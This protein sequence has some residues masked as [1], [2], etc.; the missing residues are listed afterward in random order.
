M[1]CKMSD[2]NNIDYVYGIYVILVI[3]K[4]V[5]YYLIP[6]SGSM[7][8]GSAKVFNTGTYPSYVSFRGSHCFK[9]ERKA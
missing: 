9:H 4:R 8:F 7:S 5:S 3:H 1:S 6:A 2:N